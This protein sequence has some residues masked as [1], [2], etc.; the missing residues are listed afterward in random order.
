LFVMT[1]V[2][3]VPQNKVDQYLDIQRRVKKVYSRHGCT[4]YEVFKGDDE[5]WLEINRFKDRE[6]YEN[7][8][9][10]VDLDPEIQILWKEFCSIVEKE[11]IIT[12]KYEQML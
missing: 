10:S 3:K 2:Y 12:R 4:E 11:Q 9:K 1:Y 5:L 8:E 6:H 7:V